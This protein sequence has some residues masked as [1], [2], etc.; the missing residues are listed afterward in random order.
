MYIL[1]VFEQEEL[2]SLFGNGDPFDDPNG[3]EENSQENSNKWKAVGLA[4][5]AAK[6]F[7]MS[8]KKTRADVKAESEKA[9]QIAKEL[10]GNG[11]LEYDNKKNGQ[12]F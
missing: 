8:K 2:G 5:S 12:V 9:Q 10:A 4:N 11:Y 3:G 7:E 6:N 1:C